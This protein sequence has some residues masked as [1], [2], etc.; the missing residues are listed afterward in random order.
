[1][2]TKR[3]EVDMCS[4]S[5][6]GEIGSKFNVSLVNL[7]RYAGACCPV[8]EEPA[9][10]MRLNTLHWCLLEERHSFI[11]QSLRFSCIV[12][13]AVETRYDL[14]C[15]QLLSTM[16]NAGDLSP[17][18]GMTTRETFELTVEFHL[19][20]WVPR[21]VV[22]LQANKQ[23]HHGH[24]PR[25]FLDWNQVQ[26]IL[27]WVPDVPVP[28]IIK[29]KP[30]WSGKQ[31]LSRHPSR[32]Q[33]YHGF[34]ENS[35]L[36]G[37]TAQEFSLQDTGKF[38]HRYRVDVTD[39]AGSFMPCQPQVRVNELSVEL[40]EKLDEQWER[41]CEDRK[42]LRTL[43]F[44]DWDPL[45]ERYLPVNLDRIIQNARQIFH[46][47]NRKPWDLS[48]AYIIDAV[49]E[50]EKRL[51][52][53]RGDD[54]IALESQANATLA[55][56]SHLRLTLATRPVIEGRRLMREAFDWVLGGI[57]SK[58]NA[59]LTNPG[60]MCGTLA[61]Q[62]I[63]EPGTQ[64]TLNTFHYAGVSSKNV[65]LGVPLLKEVINVA[66]NIKTPSLKIFLEPF[67]AAKRE[68]AKSTEQELALTSLRTV[69][70]VIEIWY[71]PDRDVDFSFVQ[72]FFAIHLQSSLSL[73]FRLSCVNVPSLVSATHDRRTDHSEY[74]GQ[75][76]VIKWVSL[77]TQYL[78]DITWGKGEIAVIIDWTS[79]LPGIVAGLKGSYID[80]SRMSARVGQHLKETL[81]GNLNKACNTTGQYAQKVLKED[82]NVKQMV[83][84]GSKG[85]YINISQMSVC[86]GQQS[87]E[88][89]RIPFGF[90]H[91]TLPHFEKDDFSPE[92]RGFV[93]NSYLRGLTPQEFFFHAMAGREGLIDSDLVQFVYGEDGMDGAFI[94]KQRYEICTI[95]DQE[96]E[97]RYR[98]DVT[99]PAGGFMPGQLQVGVDDSSIE[100]QEKLDEEW[101]GCDWDPL[102]ER[103]LPV[104]LDRIIQNARQIFHI[105]NRKPPDLS[106]TYI[107]DAVQ[108]LE[109]RLIVVR[110]DDIGIQDSFEVD[111]CNEAGD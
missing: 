9:T 42:T 58:F 30:L 107:I 98:V 81:E 53:G 40:Q 3:F 84:A 20:A 6:L 49:Q 28:A 24:C 97:H 90:K 18:L 37:L 44:K 11:D 86:V 89:K 105:N 4:G 22:F 77:E 5:V 110:G 47:D 13:A 88:S 16:V 95:S 63:G 43:V 35:Y 79:Y 106:P 38:E 108:E 73:R 7:A 60:E 103:Y 54:T 96:F 33:Y 15:Q 26:N 1:M 45:T 102:K 66:T 21:Q 48:P 65:T 70:A 104:N 36:C 92:S 80:I 34:V 82:N 109:K 71:D 12:T 27:L 41:L 100:L 39:P 69:T 10:Q 19:I 62:T 51:I 91:R 94:E 56:K 78:D 99:D 93:E 87:V 101:G 83:V 23:T 64:M 50:L 55:F 2:E 59:S 8:F 68:N 75:A 111:A 61:A 57:E 29:P 46:I 14:E 76:F 25:Y 67:Y 74:F 32:Y 31:I 17:L 85:S 52:V 72:D